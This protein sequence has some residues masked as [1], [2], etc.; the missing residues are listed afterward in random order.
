VLCSA[1]GVVAPALING[2]VGGSAGGKETGER[3]AG[4][5]GGRAADSQCWS[6]ARAAREEWSGG[7]RTARPTSHG[8]KAIL[9]N[10]SL[11]SVAGLLSRLLPQRQPPGPRLTSTAA[12][13]RG[14]A[15]PRVMQQVS[16]IITAGKRESSL[17]TNKGSPGKQFSC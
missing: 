10:Q 11:P 5:A 3:R 17:H 12:G 8:A 16:W 4:G 15:G 13:T 1:A 2:F 9:R 7:R 6:A 14:S